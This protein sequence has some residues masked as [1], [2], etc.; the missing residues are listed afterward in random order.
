MRHNAR[1]A[2]IEFELLMGTDRYEIFNEVNCT[3]QSKTGISMPNEAALNIK[4]LIY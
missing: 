3:A 4:I 2:C 1:S